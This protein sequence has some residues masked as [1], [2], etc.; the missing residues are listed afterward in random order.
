MPEDEQ[1]ADD[2]R[3]DEGERAPADSGDDAEPAADPDPSGD[4]GPAGD[5]EPVDDRDAELDRL[6]ERLADLE[7]QVEGQRA[8]K[9]SVAELREELESFEEDVESR[10]VDRD[11]VESD[12]KRYVRRKLRRGHA[13]GWGP[14]LVLLYGTA[15]TL[16]LLYAP[17]MEGDGWVVFA[18]IIIWL[19]VLGLYTLFVI[20][21][22]TFTVLGV[23]GRLRDRVQEWRS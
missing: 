7:D 17:K 13:R 2:D 23:P 9:A 6:Y 20:V 5:D 16:G 21:G 11:S 14:Y 15:M 12:L 4:D 19:S 18:M 10:T 22:V 1:P 3:P 8:S